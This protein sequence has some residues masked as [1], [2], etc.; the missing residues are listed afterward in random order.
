MIE[1]TLSGGPELRESFLD[2]RDELGHRRLVE[3]EARSGGRVD[4][5]ERLRAAEHQGLAVTS[6]GFRL[7]RQAVPPHLQGAHLRDAVLDVV[8]RVLEDVQLPVPSGHA[9]A[10][11][12]STRLNSSHLVI[13]YA[14]FCL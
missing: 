5:G 1:E 14:V 3:H 8:E 11:R 12:K 2:E 13:S 7:I 6:D 9:L 4:L 10:D